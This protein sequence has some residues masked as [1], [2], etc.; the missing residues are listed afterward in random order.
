MQH[1]V[2]GPITTN[3]H[4]D[5]EAAVRY[6]GRELRVSV[7]L[8]G[9]AMT[10]ALDFAASVSQRL[11]E[12]DAAAKAV[13]ANELMDTYN[14]GWNEYDEIQA[15]GTT[16]TVR[17]PELN[18]DEFIDKLVLDSLATFGDETIEFFYGNDDMFWGHSIVVTAPDGVDFTHAELFG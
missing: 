18:R 15:D 8:D 1:D 16:K 17:N 14:G 2:L 12:L 10:K 5:C 11:I 3:G 4:G 13:A 9:L 6:E 7:V